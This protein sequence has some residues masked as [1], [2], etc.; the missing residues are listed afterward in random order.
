MYVCMYVR[1]YVCAHVCQ[2]NGV[3]RSITAPAPARGCGVGRR[4]RRA[5]RSGARRVRWPAHV[6]QDVAMFVA[7]MVGLLLFLSFILHDQ[8][9]AIMVRAWRDVTWRG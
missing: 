7:L 3:I 5:A 2:L 4:D 6:Q 8:M 1:T 9:L